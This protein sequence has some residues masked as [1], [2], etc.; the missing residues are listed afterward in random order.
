MPQSLRHIPMKELADKLTVC[1]FQ[2]DFGPDRYSQIPPHGRWQH[3]EVGGVPRVSHLLN[4]WKGQGCDETEL[5]RRL[6]DL[7]FVSVLLDAGAGDTWKFKEPGTGGVYNRSEGISVAALYMFKSGA[8]SAD[9]TECV[10]DGECQPQQHP[11]IN[12]ELTMHSKGPDAALQRHIRGRLPNLTRQP[13]RRRIVPR[14]PHE[15]HWQVTREPDQHC[16]PQWPSW[17][18][19]W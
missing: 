5:A 18:H 13:P 17:Q 6:I 10:V 1:C 14:G 3:H 4:A 12:Q 19:G 7:F 15:R 9:G 16:R 11:C 2:R 8:F